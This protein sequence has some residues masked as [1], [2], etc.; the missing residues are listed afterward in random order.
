MSNRKIHPLVRSASN[1]KLAG[2]LKQDWSDEGKKEI[3]AEIA[4]RDKR[5]KHGSSTSQDN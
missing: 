1:K 3:R 2:W 5:N 4:R